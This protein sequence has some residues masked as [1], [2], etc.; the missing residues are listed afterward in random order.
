MKLIVNTVAIT[1]VMLVFTSSTGQAQNIPEGA[2]VGI[3]INS[4]GFVGVGTATPT[5]NL[6]VNG[7]LKVTGHAILNNEGRAIVETNKSD[8]LRINPDTKFPGTAMYGPVSIGT[9]GLSV[10]SWTNYP[11]GQMAVTRDTYL[12]TTGGYVGVGTTKPY[13][14]IKVIGRHHP[15]TYP[16]KQDVR[17]GLIATG[18]IFSY[19]SYMFAADFVYAKPG[20]SVA[21]DGPGG[22][23]GLETIATFSEVYERLVRLE[24]E[25]KAMKKLLCADHAGADFCR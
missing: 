2:D 19:G 6:E 9:G 15:G 17:S 10:G 8:W 18:A 13:K 20:D 14:S 22:T 25:N 12:A 16:L 7:D 11:K 1:A 3:S 23:V 4:N 5:A 21:A 24:E